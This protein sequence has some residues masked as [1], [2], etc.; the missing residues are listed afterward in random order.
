MEYSS[1]ELIFLGNFIEHTLVSPCV[2]FVWKDII[3]QVVTPSQYYSDQCRLII[4]R[5]LR[6][7]STTHLFF[8]K[9]SFSKMKIYKKNSITCALLDQILLKGR[10]C[11]PSSSWAFQQYQ[12][13]PAGLRRGVQR[14]HIKTRH[15]KHTHAAS[16]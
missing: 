8:V 12:D 11:T 9:K 5:V 4:F 2:P 1:S 14:G 7:L 13:G 6:K 15:H 3:P 10:T 16:R